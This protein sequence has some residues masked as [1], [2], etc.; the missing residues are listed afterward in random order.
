MLLTIPGLLRV[1]P[2]CAPIATAFIG[3]IN[4]ALIKWG[5]TTGPSVAA[6]LGQAA[7][8]SN[9]LLTLEENLHYT[10]ERLCAVWPRR[11]WMPKSDGPDAL[12]EVC[13]ADK[14]PA[15]VY[16]GNPEA[17]ANAIYAN[18]LGNGDRESG[19]GWR[20]R[21]RG[22]FQLTGR[23]NYKAYEDASGVTVIDIPDLLFDPIFASDSAGWFWNKH[24]LTALAD[25]GDFEG[26]T[27]IINGGLHGL[28]QRETYW[29]RAL[30][31]LNV[32]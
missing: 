1:M 12:A 10:A 24:G 17:I 31:M 32:T 29:K 25:R 22:I 14:E 18:R 15:Q 2:R 13:P 27:R 26:I 7:H 8:E 11:F 4:Q 23:T 30:A 5:I 21:G 19:D 16:E 6:F 20:Y 28:P 3:P 9:E